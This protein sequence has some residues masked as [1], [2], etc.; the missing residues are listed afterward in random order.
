MFSLLLFEGRNLVK[1]PPNPKLVNVKDR[2][3]VVKIRPHN[4]YSSGVKF[5]VSIGI[6]MKRSGMTINS[7]Q[8]LI[9]VSDAVFL[10]E[11]FKK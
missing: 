5:F 1:A 6:L 8:A 2:L 3:Q 7:A 10:Y 9:N 11:F 4:P